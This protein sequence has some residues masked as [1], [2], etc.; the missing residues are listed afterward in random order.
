MRRLGPALLV[1][2]CSAF[3]CAA[4]PAYSPKECPTWEGMG[5]IEVNPAGAPH[6]HLRLQAAF[7]VCPPVEGLAEIE[8]KR[9]ELRHEMISLLS[10]Q[11]VADLEDPLRAE[12]LRKQLMVLVNEGVLKKARVTDVFI[13]GM[14][15][16]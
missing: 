10:R 7:R 15:L 3:G 6:R 4:T 11:S 13:T 9:I 16:Q 5:P 2:V 8:R 14:H 1:A 12:K